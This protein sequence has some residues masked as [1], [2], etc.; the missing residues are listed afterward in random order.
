[1]CKDD[2]LQQKDPRSR[3][4]PSSSASVAC[5]RSHVWQE[6]V[7]LVDWIVT[8]NLVEGGVAGEGLFLKPLLRGM[9][10]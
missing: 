8:Q 7:P 6:T 3:K 10:T 1:M 4:K 5:G 2:C 9:E